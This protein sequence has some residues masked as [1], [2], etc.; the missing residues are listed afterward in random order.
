LQPWP[1][2]FP[3]L[4]VPPCAWDFGVL[5][6]TLHYELSAGMRSDIADEASAVAVARLFADLAGRGELW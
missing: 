6:Q 1:V 5:Q 4:S 3:L 2:L